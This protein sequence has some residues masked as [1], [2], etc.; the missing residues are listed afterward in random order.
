NM[1]GYMTYIA[2]DKHY[3]FIPPVVE[4]IKNPKGNVV[5]IIIDGIHRVLLA[6]KL[7]KKTITIIAIESVPEKLLVPASSNTWKEVKLMKNAPENKDKRKW[8]ISAEK[9]YFYYRN[10]NSAFVNVGKPRK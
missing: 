4:Y 6:K 8:L 5:R 3:T 2:N 1:K 10:F 9:G 7:K